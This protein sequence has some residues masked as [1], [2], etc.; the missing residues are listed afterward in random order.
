VISAT[1]AERTGEFGIR[2]ALGAQPGDVLTLVLKHG[3]RLAVFGVVIGLVGA[4]G[5]GRLLS[6][7]LP[8]LPSAD[9]AVLGG[10]A[11]TLFVVA[12]VAC[13]LPARWATKVDPIRT[14]RAE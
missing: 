11:A 5:L 3:L 1:V 2:L 4:F 7:L 8:R 12:L 13:W 14:L 10:V 9:L 6:A